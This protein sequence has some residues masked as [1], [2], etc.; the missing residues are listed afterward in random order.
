MR[1]FVSNQ[2]S[3]VLSDALFPGIDIIELDVTVEGVLLTGLVRAPSASCPHCGTTS[4]SV[5]SYYTRRP[6]DLPLCGQP[7]HLVLHVRRFRCLLPTCSAVTFAE[8]LPE[9]VAPAAQ[10]TVRLN[11]T[12][13]DL[14]L[15]FGGEAGARQSGRS[16]MAASGDTLLR[17]AHAATHPPQPTPRILGIDDFAFQK[18]QVYGTIL[19]NGETHAVVDLLPDRTAETASVW[20]RTHPGIEVITRDRASEYARA[21]R[22]GAPNAVQVAD[23]FH[24]TKNAGDVLERIVQRHHQGLRSAAKAVDREQMAMLL[25]FKEVQ[26]A[27]PEQEKPGPTAAS[28][29]Q[30]LHARQRRLAQYQEVLALSALGLGPKAIGRQVGLTRQT[31]ALWLKAGAFPERRPSAPRRMM[32]TPYEP[33]LREQW[34]AGCHNARQL[35]RELQAQGFR[36]GH[37]TVERFLVQW[38]TEPGFGGPPR[39]QPSP[40][41]A[42]QAP[43]PPTTRPLSPRQAR[44]LL[45]KE[46]SKLK[47][48]QQAYLQHFGQDCPEVLIVQSLRIYAARARARRTCARRVANSGRGK[49][50]AG[51]GG[52][53]QRSRA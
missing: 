53:R 18:G 1:T 46:E 14:A 2:T 45:L 37:A 24:L 40:P 9:L 39:R 35:W 31:V 17:R 5:H 25:P 11:T 4:T 15:A 21:G 52:V 33:Y 19:T 12:L 28:S 51:A 26:I 44:W 10:R 32:I 36:G 49:R 8:H 43:P 22:E 41:P 3:I 23:R 50:R 13:R 7:V 27:L 29:R 38:R 34:A 20:L 47:P 42:R 48:E 16:A 30:D 6:H